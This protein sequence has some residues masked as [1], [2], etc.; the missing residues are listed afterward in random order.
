MKKIVIFLALT[1]TPLS[2]YLE[3]TEEQKK[4]LET[5]APDKR[6]ALMTKMEK[7]NGLEEEISEVFEEEELLTRRPEFDELDEEDLCDDCIFGYEVFK[8]SPSSFSSVDNLPV[9]DSYV[10]GPGDEIYLEYFGTE[11]Q[12]TKA[13]ISR[14]GTL[15]LPLIGELNLNG[16]TFKEAKKLIKN[17]VSN[18]L[19]GTSASI[20]FQKL[21]SITVFVLG[22]A[23]KP[24]AYTISALSSVSNALFI[25]GGVNENG[26]LRN[27]QIKRDN[28]VIST[29]DFYDLLLKGNTNTEVMLREGDVIYIPFIENKV[30]LGG[31]VKRPH[32]YE[33]VKGETISDAIF[34]AGGYKS[35]TLVSKRIELSSLN[36]T[37][38]NRELQV[39]DKD[40]EDLNLVLLKD[41]DLISASELAGM[42]PRSVELKG[43]FAKPGVYSLQQGDTILDLIDRAGGYTDEAF[44]QGAVFLREEI[45][46]QQKAAFVRTAD[47]LERNLIN[48]ISNGSL[49][50]ISEFTLTPIVKLIDRLRDEE[51]LGRQVVD[52][53]YLTIKSDP[54]KNFMVRDGDILFVPKRP[55]SVTVVGEVL[56]GSSLRYDPSMSTSDYISLAGG[57]SD[58]ADKSRVF[59]I[60]PDGNASVVKRSFFS[61]ETTILPGSTIVVPRSPRY[62]DAIAITGIITPVLADLATSA[63]AIAAISD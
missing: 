10:L 50:N 21:R 60:T 20:A 38:Q 16:L 53:E 37:T 28:E 48:L 25:S 1:F 8:F 11:K 30:R 46:E 54:M 32:L 29:Y 42:E 61:Q 22:E 52:V 9:P 55:N 39:Y 12:S 23:Y 2:L 47:S 4:L 3:I 57:F 26:S 34:L 6:E 7:A 41:G 19:I 33:F 13:F 31:A 27:I 36:S 14:N 62:L 51:P 63:A 24:G 17:K 35:S 43:E 18:E 40:S 5:L 56:N 59:A 45:A 15:M 58:Q 44:T 49:E